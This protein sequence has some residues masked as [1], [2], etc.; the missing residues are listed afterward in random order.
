MRRAL[1]Q[2]VEIAG[3]IIRNDGRSKPCTVCNLTMNG[4]K[5]SL[6]SRDELP[7]EFTVLV[8]GVNRRSRLV[9]RTGLHAGVEFVT[10]DAP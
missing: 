5:L 4:A 1:R 7:T 6:L 8:D 9:W 2:P 3:W 10:A